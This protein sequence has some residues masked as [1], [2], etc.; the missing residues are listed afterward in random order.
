MTC[1]SRIIG[2]QWKK[3]SVQKQELWRALATVNSL[4]HNFKPAVAYEFIYHSKRKSAIG[5][6]ILATAIS[7]IVLAERA[8]LAAIRQPSFKPKQNAP[9]AVTAS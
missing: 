9:S 3:L 1:I 6:N 2:K 8:A 4:P 7:P 5:R